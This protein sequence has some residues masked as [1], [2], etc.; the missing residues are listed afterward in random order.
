[1]DLL[2]YVSIDFELKI[3][4]GFLSNWRD[5]YFEDMVFK[6]QIHNQQFKGENMY[7]IPK[8]TFYIG[9]IVRVP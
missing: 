8:Y 6:I 7:L 5:P 9:R 3:G 2:K 1:M 4:Y